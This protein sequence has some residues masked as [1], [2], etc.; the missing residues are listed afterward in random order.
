MERP[1]VEVA[2]IFGRFGRSYLE[3]YPTSRQQRRVMAAITACRTAALGG[4]LERCDQCEHERNAYNSCRDRHCP[5]CGSL[6]REQW[7]QA[8]CAEL[9]PIAYFHIV[10]TMPEFLRPVAWQNQAVVYNILFQS[11]A[12]ALQKVAADP[13]H[14]GARIGLLAILHT[15]NQQ[16]LYHPHVHC[17]VSGGGPS[18]DDDRWIPAR[19]NFFLPVAVLS[20]VYRGVFMQALRRAYQERKLSWYGE[21]EHLQDPAAFDHYIQAAWQKE[22]VVYSKAPF[23]EPQQVVESVGRYIHGAAISNYRLISLDASP[24][25]IDHVVEYF[26]KHANR[27]AITNDRLVSVDEA[28]VTFSWQDRCH[29]QTQLLTITG[30][31]FMRRFLM[32]VVPPHFVRIRHYGY[33]AN[34]HRTE[35]LA[36]CRRLLQVFES[37]PVQD[38]AVDWK[39]RLEK[40]SGVDVDQCPMCPLGR[41]RM[42]LPLL[43]QRQLRQR[44][45]GPQAVAIQD[46]S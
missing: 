4:H 12:A 1:T 14:L 15:W 34:A 32:H 7:V 45:N 26:G 24:L 10:F 9:L 23:A 44:P 18:P 11:A 36:L 22:W 6:A 13:Q 2:D 29:G 42:V 30:H 27:I 46:S 20:K 8:R 16:L 31:E 28:T 3:Q 40:L 35:Q 21:L 37:A 19:S 17:I 33:L 43:P 25:G 41:M 5:K 39:T 38:P